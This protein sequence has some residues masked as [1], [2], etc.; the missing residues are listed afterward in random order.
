MKKHIIMIN[1]HIKTKNNYL[2]CFVNGPNRIF[3]P[4]SHEL[5]I[6]AHLPFLRVQTNRRQHHFL[7]QSREVSLATKMFPIP[8]LQIRWKHRVIWLFENDGWLGKA[9]A[10]HR[11]RRTDQRNNLHRL[12]INGSPW[13]HF[14][15][16]RNTL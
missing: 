2:Y 11:G 9:K 3:R 1:N 5:F 4:F 15:F 13:L 7:S 8:Q 12:S 6:R 10:E 16:E 14:P